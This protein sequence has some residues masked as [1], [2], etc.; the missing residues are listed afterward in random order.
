ME[1]TSAGKWLKKHG[2]FA[3]GVGAGAALDI[4]MELAMGNGLGDGIKNAALE[5]LMF[6]MFPTIGFTRMLLLPAAQ[7]GAQLGMAHYNN[8]K[9]QYEDVFDDK[10]GGDYQ[11][12]KA[13]YTMRQRGMQAIQNSR[14]NARSALGNTAKMMHRL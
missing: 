9:S 7:A 2:D 5:G 14:M 6:E 1:K 3:K 4:G 13:A 8:D 10:M 12:S 11:D